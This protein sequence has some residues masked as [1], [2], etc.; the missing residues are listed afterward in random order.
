[1]RPA[2]RFFS[3]VTEKHH[4]VSAILFLLLQIMSF[5]GRIIGSNQR[6]LPSHLRF[7]RLQQRHV[8][9]RRD[10]LFHTTTSALFPVNRRRRPSASSIPTE[11][12]KNEDGKQDETDQN[13]AIV[14][15]P[16]QFEVASNLLIDKLVAALR[17]LE[18][19]NDPF[20]LT[21]GMETDLGKY[22][23]L[24]LGPVNG[25]YTVQV[26]LEQQSLLFRSPISGQLAYHVTPA[27]NWCS[28]VDGHNFEGI[29]VRDLIRQVQGVPNL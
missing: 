5:L 7:S 21:V 9:E 22:I 8:Y 13:K 18:A 28:N 29:F 2:T 27:G 17:P 6:R 15:D 19:L 20:L 4:R 10:V 25:Q 16:Q 24:D 26:D 23:L 14:T 3:V 1:M 11:N 12:P